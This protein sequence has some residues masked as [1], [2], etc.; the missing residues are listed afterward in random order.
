MLEAVLGD[1]RRSTEASTAQT[2]TIGCDIQSGTF[3]S[4]TMN[5]YNTTGDWTIP[6]HDTEVKITVVAEVSG[7]FETDE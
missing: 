4:L 7:A 5:S 2:P 1:K 6:S 3:T